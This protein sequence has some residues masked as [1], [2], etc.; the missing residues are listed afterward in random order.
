MLGDIDLEHCRGPGDTLLYASVHHSFRVSVAVGRAA[1]CQH[2]C[3]C[4]HLV[5]VPPKYRYACL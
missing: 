2:R 4:T 3:S 5:L 1:G